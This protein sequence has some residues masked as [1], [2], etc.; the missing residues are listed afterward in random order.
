MNN[1]SFSI[2]GQVVLLAER[3]IV[4]A[5][6]TID[7]G[8]ISKIEAIAKAPDFFILPGFVDAHIHI[9]S[10]M[11]IPSEF[12]PLAVKHGT[13]ATVSD[14]H[15]IA[16]VLGIAGIDFML[17]DAAKVPFKFF[18]GAPSCV[19]AT[20]FET[21]GAT[22]GPDAIESLLKRKEIS[23]L[24]EMMNYP[25]VLNKDPQVLEK[26]VIAK[27]LNK[28]IDGHA[29]GLRGNDIKSYID[30]GI[31]SDHECTTYEEAKEKITYG[32]KILI[33]EGSAAKN[34]DALIDLLAEYP[35]SIMF[36]SDDKHPHDLIKGHINQLVKRS[37][38]SGMDLYD[39]LNAAITNPI[40]HYGL[41]VGQ[42]RVGD[43]A[44][45]ILVKDL[46]DF[47]VLE[48][49]I[50]G[51]KV[52]GGHKCL[53]Q[54]NNFNT[55]NNFKRNEIEENFIKLKGI[56]GTYRVIK[57]LDGQLLTHELAHQMMC[58]PDG[59][60]EADVDND[61]LKI[62][63]LSRYDQSKAAIALVKGFELKKGAIASSVAHDSHNI[64][65]VGTNDSDLRSAINL[66]IKNKGGISLSDGDVRESISLPVAGLMTNISGEKLA[67]NYERLHELSR[68]LGSTLY[69]PFMMLSFCALLVIPELKLSDKGL[70]NGNTF[71]FVDLLKSNY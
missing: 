62:I 9:E 31:S 68:S 24:A 69:D 29:P 61:V 33:R 12:A 55:P 30:Q 39:T 22:L 17:D 16:N 11:L 59:H 44:D 50:N 3:K 23:Y 19:P 38:G 32:M 46:K 34:F 51:I 5:R 7:H 2:S 26:L 18:F 58:S 64:I 56:S 48:T 37:I 53:F 14:P 28:K 40:K 25:G 20:D 60:I 8:I 10:S 49:Y 71:N 6:L 27:R 21:A 57:V 63:V 36:C 43:P 41:E 1:S 65:A 13:I 67:L 4:S 66:I 42:L 52:Y 35:E 47:D 70:F 15:E 54:S 45:F